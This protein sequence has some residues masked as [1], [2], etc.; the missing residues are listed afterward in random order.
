MGRHS[1]IRSNYGHSLPAISLAGKICYF[2][3]SKSDSSY[4]YNHGCLLASIYRKGQLV[5]NFKLCC[6]ILVAVVE[7]MGSL[8]AYFLEEARVSVNHSRLI[9]VLQ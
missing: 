5:L 3:Y 9:A 4:I 1:G 7:K 2:P 8:I 6:D